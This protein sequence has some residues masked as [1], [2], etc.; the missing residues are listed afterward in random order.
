MTGSLITKKKI[1]K[2]FKKLVTDIGFEKVTIAKIMQ[3]SHMRR[4]TFYDYFQD[5]YELVDW[6][7]QQEAIEKIE[8]NL[9]Y[10]GWQVIVENLFA[11]FEE[12]QIFYR[13][14]LLFD[15]Q[16]SFQ[17]YYT[18]HLKV[19]IN[20]VL[21]VKYEPEDGIKESDRLFLENFYASA[22]V[23]LTT[24]WIVEGCKTES[25]CFAEQMKLAFL[26]GFKEKQ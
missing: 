5:K 16:N 9:T 11:Y 17:E 26:M 8:D 14:I 12:N 1:A 23:S 4:Q 2:V 7:F 13:K 20:Q 21:V 6:I 19:L 24:K 22:F 15:G 18:R 3:E 25:R 10:E